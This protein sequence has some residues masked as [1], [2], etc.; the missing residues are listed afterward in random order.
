MRRPLRL[1]ALLPLLA[2]SAAAQT[3]GT[4]ALGTATDT[5]AANDVRAALYNTGGLFWKGNGPLYTVPASA[6]G[7]PTN[8]IFSATL[9]VGGTVNGQLRMSAAN[10][11]GWEMWP[12]PLDAGGTLPS[13]TD[14]RAYDRIWRV[15]RAEIRAYYASGALPTDLREWPVGLGAPAFVDANRNA[16]RDAG[17]AL[18]A[19][20]SRTQTLDLAAG[21]VPLLLGEATS[22]WVMNDVGNTKRTTGSLPI[23]LEV[24]VEVAAMPSLDAA[25]DQTTVYRYTLVNRSA[26]PLTQAYVGLWSDADLG[27]GTDDHMGSD[28]TRSLV[29]V[30]NGDNLDEGDGAYGTPPPALGLRVL[31]GPLVAAPGLTWTDPDGTAYADRQR[32]PMTSSRTFDNDYSDGINPALPYL[33]ALRGRLNNGEPMRACGNGDGTAEPGCSVTAFAFGGDPVTGTGWSALNLFPARPPAVAARPDDRQ[34]LASAGPFDLAPG[35]TQTVTFAYVFARGTSHLNSVTALREASDRVQRAWDTGAYLRGTDPGTSPALA[36]PTLLAPSNGATGQPSPVRLL[37][38]APA[39]DVTAYDVQISHDPAFADA[40]TRTVRTATASYALV[41]DSTG[42]PAFWRARAVA[43][44]STGAEVIGPWSEAW[45]F[46]STPRTV[47]AP[48]IRFEFQTVANAAG[49]LAPPEPGAFGSAG[50]PV[51]AGRLDPDGTRQQSTGGL[52]ANQGWAIFTSGSV[53]DYNG[54]WSRVSRDGTNAD[55]IHAASYEWRFIGSSKAVDFFSAR[56]AVVEVPF[57]LWSLGADVASADDDV[58]M[59]PLL[60][61][62]CSGTGSSVGTFDIGG[63]SPVSDGADDPISDAVYWV[64]PQDRTPGQAGYLAYAADPLGAVQQNRIGAEVW[65]RMTL[66]GRNFGTSAYPMALPER[67]TVLRIAGTFDAGTAPALATPASGA[68]LPGPTVALR[69]ASGLN[70]RSS[71]YPVP[72]YLVEVQVARDAAFTDLVVRDTVTQDTYA[73]PYVAS[74]PAGGR[75]YWRVRH[76]SLGP[77][78]TPWSEAWTFTVGTGTAGEA[79]ARPAALALEAPRPNPSRGTARLRVGMP[80]GGAARVD[81]VDVLGR[82]VAVVHDGPLAAGWTDV[83]VETAAL[84]P[85]VYVVRLVAGRTA[86]TQALVVAR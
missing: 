43:T 9:W 23:G 17:E 35:E 56:N 79:V 64:Y 18:V 50:F 30:Y 74:L 33:N 2:A 26:K 75:Y 41:P 55:E 60:C 20:T 5:L 86:R 28:S 69:W 72:M 21:Q 14:C 52:R 16:L 46:T 13:A 19:A 83:P 32:M 84:A 8:A 67:G 39:P 22:W 68:A 49:P 77:V 63:D 73:T 70:F 78:E 76:V 27:N 10:Y 81:V 4:C 31:G 42:R 24:R 3:T 61:D 11:G 58:R 71:S 15:S 54:W 47:T 80:E 29:Y 40:T 59:I 45:T 62:N 34:M 1:L 38:Q 7:T 25:I 37:W 57:E 12:G 53:L 82:R 48:A 51:P 65:A 6:P 44:R 85:G 36:A 66:V